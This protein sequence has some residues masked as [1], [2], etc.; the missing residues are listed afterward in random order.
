[1]VAF[2]LFVRYL[3][4]LVKKGLHVNYCSSV[5]CERNSLLNLAVI[6]GR[7]NVVRWL[8]EEKQADIESCDRGQ[9]TPLMNA[10]YDGDRYLVVSRRSNQC[11]SFH[12][13]RT[14]PL[15]TSMIPYKAL[16]H[17]QRG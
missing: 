15:L 13:D 1:M 4:K 6:N 2:Q 9:F 8:V 14:G 3:E 17:D 7:K 12:F 11:L 16:L 10:A 5:V